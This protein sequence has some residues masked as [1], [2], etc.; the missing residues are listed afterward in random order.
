MLHAL[1][2]D[3]LTTFEG[4]ALLDRY[5]LYQHLME[6][7]K[8]VWLDDAYQV[9]AEGWT[10]LPL[11]PGKTK[12]APSYSELVPRPLL[13]ARHLPEAQAAVDQL[14]AELVQRTREREEQEEEHGTEDGA[15]ASY[16]NEDGSV[17]A[18]GVKSRA[19]KLRKLLKSKKTATPKKSKRAKQI[20]E[21]GTLA[22]DGDV[23]AMAMEVEATT[24]SAIT[25][26]DLADAQAELATLADYLMVLDAEADAKKALKEARQDLD[27]QVQALYRV[28]TPIQVQDLLVEDKWLASLHLGAQ[29]QMNRLAQRLAR[30]VTELADRYAQPMPTLA[31][32][33]A[34][35]TAQVQAHLKR[36]GFAVE[37]EQLLE[38]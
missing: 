36:M 19:V 1:A 24:L 12:T 32:E 33:V 16:L 31:A 29:R 20:A 22:L 30:R 5:D 8:E 4:V 13:V 25:A 3:L 11:S 2:E 9:V 15:L 21:Q 27:A 7:G 38:N 34:K 23:A 6:Y 10:V 14:E 35:D 37:L 18:A 28:L 26:D 17:D